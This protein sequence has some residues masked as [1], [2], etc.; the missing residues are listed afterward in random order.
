M[1]EQPICKKCGETLGR[2]S[3]TKNGIESFTDLYLCE[4]CMTIYK[5]KTNIEIEEV[6][7]H[8]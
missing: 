7:K 5:V 6:K 4:G 2:V 8:D 3:I 1:S